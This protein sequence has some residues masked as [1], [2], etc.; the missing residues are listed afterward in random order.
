MRSQRPSVDTLGRRSVDTAV[1]TL[2][3]PGTGHYSSRMAPLRVMIAEDVLVVRAG[4]EALLTSEGSVQVVGACSNYDD[5]VTN[6]ARDKPD[7][8]ITDIK[9]PPTWTD[10]GIRAACLLRRTHP[11]VAVV[12]LSHYLDSTYL[13]ALIAEGSSR[14]GYLLKERVANS[15]ELTSAVQTVAAGG[16]FIDPVV[17]D[18]LVAAESRNERTPLKRLTRR[19]RETLAAVASGKSNSAIAFMLG[20]SERAIEKNI[21]SIFLKLDLPDDGESN[22]RV[23]AVLMFLHPSGGP[24]R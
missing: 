18:A 23:K 5:L 10:E 9:M 24:G 22:R 1:Q 15:G 7:V 17:V 14:R 6:V 3:T 13:L 4:I 20:V 8:V 11:Q 16:S 12:V 2:S 19:E 21:S